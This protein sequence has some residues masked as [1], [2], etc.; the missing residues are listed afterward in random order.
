MNGLVVGGV[1]AAA[2]VRSEVAWSD[3]LG[4]AYNLG[5]VDGCKEGGGTPIEES[6]RYRCLRTGVG[7]EAFRISYLGGIPGDGSGIGMGGMEVWAEGFCTEDHSGASIDFEM[8]FD[9]KRIWELAYA[10]PVFSSAVIDKMFEGEEIGVKGY[11]YDRMTTVMSEGQLTLDHSG[12]GHIK[13]V[14]DCMDVGS[15]AP[16]GIAYMKEVWGA[17][18]GVTIDDLY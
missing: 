18:E 11:A 15:F 12:V 4:K 5:Y 10:S 2:M 3:Q 13:W 6:D 14:A 8:A 1:I 9:A 17:A 7:T 16:E